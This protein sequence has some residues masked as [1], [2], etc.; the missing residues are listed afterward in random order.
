VVFILKAVD[1]YTRSPLSM[2]GLENYDRL[3]L[4]IRRTTKKE[5]FAATWPSFQKRLAVDYHNT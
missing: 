1:R 4:K 2:Q 3:W 5:N